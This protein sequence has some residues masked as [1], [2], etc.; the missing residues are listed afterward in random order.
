MG[1]E[2]QDDGASAGSSPRR[3]SFHGVQ[4]GPHHL[5]AA[6]DSSQSRRSCVPPPSGAAAQEKLARAGARQRWDPSPN[7]GGD[8]RLPGSTRMLLQPRYETERRQRM[9]QRTARGLCP[10]PSGLRGARGHATG[11]PSS[12][13]GDGACGRCVA[14]RQ[15]RR[16]PPCF[17]GLHR[18]RIDHGGRRLGMAPH[19]GAHGFT[20]LIVDAPPG[21]ILTP[22]AQIVLGRLPRRQIMRHQAPGTAGP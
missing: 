22:G 14:S 13:R 3:S 16:G 15:H 9:R 10:R 19:A 12:R 17:G 2:G 11:E 4:G 20:E 7:A 1:P 21:A 5:C 18:W 8:G 6:G